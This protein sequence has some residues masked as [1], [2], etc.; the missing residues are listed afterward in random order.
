MDPLYCCFSLWDDTPDPLSVW[1]ALELLSPQWNWVVLSC[2]CT[3]DTS[4]FH[5]AIKWLAVGQT[6]AECRARDP[7]CVV[8]PLASMAPKTNSPPW[9]A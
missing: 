1:P 7:G 8:K 2:A 4:L 6:F 5:R 3:L 9:V